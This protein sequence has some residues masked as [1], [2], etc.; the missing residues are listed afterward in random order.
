MQDF[1]LRVLLGSSSK[2]EVSIMV[3]LGWVSVEARKVQSA[4]SPLSPTLSTH[5]S[6]SHA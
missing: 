3:L 6:P 4:F 1:G 5:R 2:R